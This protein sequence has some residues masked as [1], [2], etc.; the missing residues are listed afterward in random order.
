MKNSGSFLNKKSIS[1]HLILSLIAVRASNG[2][3][4]KACPGQFL[5]DSLL[6]PQNPVATRVRKI[7]G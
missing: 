4:F 5:E 2:E 1:N 6:A 7:Y 3:P